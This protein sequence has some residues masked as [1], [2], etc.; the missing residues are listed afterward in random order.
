MMR[1][2]HTPERVM[3]EFLHRATV[4]FEHPTET[5]VVA[6]AREFADCFGIGQSEDDALADLISDIDS[7]TMSALIEAKMILGIYEPDE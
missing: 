2:K 5:K 7:H 3:H 1:S 4:R 6:T